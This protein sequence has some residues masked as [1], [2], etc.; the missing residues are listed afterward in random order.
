M[1]GRVGGVEGSEWYWIRILLA[2]D[3]ALTIA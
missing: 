3:Q 2:F 1:T